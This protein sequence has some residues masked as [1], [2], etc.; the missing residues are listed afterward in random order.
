MKKLFF[1]IVLISSS[2]FAQ[3]NVKVDLTSP[4]STIYTHLYFLQADSYNASKAALTIRGVSKKEAIAKAIKIKE[5]FDGK[6]LLIDVDNLPTDKNYLDTISGISGGSIEETNHHYIPFPDKIPEIYVEKV[7]SRW[8]YSKET[9]EYIDEIHKEIFPWEFKWLQKKFP[10][11]FEKKIEGVNIW[12]PFAIL[13]LIG[14]CILFI[15]ILKRILFFILRKTQNLVLHDKTYKS[16]FELFSEI[17]RIIALLI[18][19]VIVERIL[20]SFQLFKIN[21]FLFLA[22]DIAETVFFVYLIIKIIKLILL[23]Y[24]D[25]SQKTHSKLDEQLA[26]ILNKLLLGIV[27]FIGFLHILT[28]FG[29]EPTT[30]LAGASIGGVAI[31]FAAQDSVKNLIGT[32]NIFLDKPFRLGDWVVI[33][34]VEGTVEHVGLRSTQ[35]RAAD[36]S[37]FQI[38]N[39]KVSEME[40]NNKGLR[41]FRRYNTELGIRYD[42]PPEL[43]EAFVQGIRKIIIEHPDTRSESFNVEFTGFGDS[44]LKIL[45]NVFFKQLDWGSEQSSK[46]RLHIAIVKLASALGVGFA[47]PSSTLMIE[48]L[49]G[50]ESL[51]AKYNTNKKDI[52]SSIKSVLKEFEDMDHEVD[53]NASSLPD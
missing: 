9:I 40:I 2:I 10:A 49:P 39:S 42:T 47:F 22:L 46:H 28:L 35:V 36:T 16:S 21:N 14:L 4:K 41:I 37:V 15:K 25:F 12:K 51:A 30:V 20:P 8:Y 26:P 7:G 44:A 24:S 5:V 27:V 1:F 31:A 48:Q 3:N 17:S 50:Q 13:I 38:P 6:G 32:I 43:I 45:V 18:M 34:G 29:V 52:E 19:L 53:K 33:G 23:Y 11:I